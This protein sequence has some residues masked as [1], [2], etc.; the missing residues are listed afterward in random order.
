[1]DGPPAAPPANAVDDAPDAAEAG[2]R[3]RLWTPWRMRYVGGGSAEAGCVFCRRLAAADDVRSLILHRGRHAFAIMNLYPYNTGHLMLVPSEHAASPERADPAAL[4]EMA[5]LVPPTLRA[6][7]R[8]LGCD[9]FN[10]GMNVGA[11]AGAGVADHL[12]EHVVPRWEGDASFMPILAATMV[13]PELIPVTYAKVRAELARELAGADG[14]DCVVLNAAKDHILAAP[15]GPSWRLP[16]AGAG[17]DEALWRAAGRLVGT[18]VGEAEVVGWG[19]PVSATEPG[20]ALTFVTRSPADAPLPAGS[21]ARWLPAETAAET[22]ATEAAI[23]N[24]A[25]PGAAL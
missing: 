16:R 19:G 15:D 4:A 14:V 21:P 2:D 7:R 24:L 11:D 5:A 20:T 9:G 10:L 23:A 18:L 22:L 8:V 17:A 1:M 12:H 6:L 13:M 3:Q 25:G